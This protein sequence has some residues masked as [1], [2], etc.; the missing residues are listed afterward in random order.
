M[1]REFATV[2]EGRMAPLPHLPAL[3]D[4]KAMCPLLSLYLSQ[5]LSNFNRLIPPLRGI[6]HILK[7]WDD[8]LI[9]TRGQLLGGGNTKLAA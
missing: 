8:A 1:N 9:D 2:V 7:C 6:C 3:D 5:S 4:P